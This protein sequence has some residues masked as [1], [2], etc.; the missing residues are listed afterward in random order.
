MSKKGHNP[1]PIPP[2]NQ[3]PAGP[4]YTPGKDDEEPAGGETNGGAS[5]QEQDPKR[6]LGDYGT[7]GEHPRQQP[8]RLND[9]ETHNK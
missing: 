6:R 9:G 4:G 5:F 1:G 3:S 2:G 7:T 8:S